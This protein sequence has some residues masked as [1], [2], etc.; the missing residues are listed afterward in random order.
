MDKPIRS[1]TYHK[2]LDCII[3]SPG[4]VDVQHCPVCGDRMDERRRVTGPTCLAEALAKRGH[5]HDVFYCP[6]AAEPWHVQARN[7]VI[8]IR[9]TPSHRLRAIVKEE[10]TAI[11]RDR[12]ACVEPFE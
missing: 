7:L 12:P 8:H 5:L 10:L 1:H 3:A 11:I 4:A 9:E 2:G 6:H